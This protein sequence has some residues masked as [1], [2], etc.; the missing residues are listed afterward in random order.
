VTRAALVTG[1]RGGIGAAIVE[2]LQ[3]DGWSVQGVL[4]AAGYTATKHQRRSVRDTS[5]R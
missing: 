1:A 3:A 5:T 4:E 2:R